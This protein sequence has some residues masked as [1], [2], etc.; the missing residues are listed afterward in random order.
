M[1]LSPLL[2]ASAIVQNCYV[3]AD[4]DQACRAF[5]DAFGIGP[6]MGGDPFA[7]E[8]HSYRGEAQPPIRARGAFVQSGDL[9]IELIQILSDGPSAFHDMFPR[10]GAGGLHHA[11]MFAD[12]YEARQAQFVAAGYPVV[13]EFRVVA[14]DARI[15]YLDTRPLLG[16]MIELYPENAGIR[17]MYAQ[18]RAAAQRWDGGRLIV[19]W[20]EAGAA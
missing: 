14:L 15:C 20:G 10:P 19:P 7:L 17:A 1:S 13:S 18:A 2:P 4:L 6:F 3:V 8:E 12:D 11:A 16:H 9:N 5:H